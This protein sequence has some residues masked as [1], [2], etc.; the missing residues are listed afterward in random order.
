MIPNPR[1]T[2]LLELLRASGSVTVEG[3]AEQVGVTLQ[4]VRRD[5]KLLEQAGLLAR[6]HGGARLHLLALDQGTS[7][8]RAIVFHRAAA[9]W[10]W[11]SAS[12]GRSSR[13]PAGSSTTPTRSGD[14]A[15][16]A[17]RGAGR[18]GLQA[19]DIAAIG[20]TNQRETTVLWNRR[21]GPAGAQRHRLAGPPHRAA[22]RA[23]ARAGGLVDAG[24]RAHRAGDRPL[25]LGTKL[26][27]LLDHVNGAHIAAARGELAFGTVDSWLL[28]KLTGGRVHATDV[29]NARARCCSTSATTP[30][31]TNC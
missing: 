14:P 16:T 21:T 28:W 23:A 30:G 5:M 10:P 29:S 11:R 26:R 25:L 12:S 15:R 31:T 19:G 9:S 27:W 2:A 1:Q 4:T 7:S 18:A 17:R 8:S 22:V 24:A 13:S 3:V 20:I 6:F